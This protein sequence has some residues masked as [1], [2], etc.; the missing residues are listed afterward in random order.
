MQIVKPIIFI[1]LFCGYFLHLKRK[2]SIREEF[3]P[4]IIVTIIG[5]VEYLAGIL[6]LL[7]ITTFLIGIIGVILFI[8]NIYEMFKNKEKIKFNKNI[9]VYILLILWAVYILKGTI[10]IHYDN[11]SHWAMIIREMI[12]TNKLP[13]FQS[14]LILFNSYPPATACFVY[15]VCKYLGSTEAIMLLGQSILILSSLYT[16]C[17][18]CKKENKVNYIIL[19]GT[20]FYIL[21]SNIFI[22]ELLVDTVLP[23]MGLGALVIILYYNENSKNGLFCS[24]PILTLLMLV[25]NS[26]VFFVV[27]DLA[28]W[29]RLFIKN[30]GFKNIF[31][32]K[33]LLLIL[34]PILVQIIWTSHT[35]LVFDNSKMTKHSM[36]VENYIETVNQKE[37]SDINTII[38]GMKTRMIN[39]KDTDNQVLLLTLAVFIFMIIISRKNK[40]LR[41]F[42][43]KMLCLCIITYIFYQI[44]LFGMYM[45]SMPIGEALHLASYSRYFKTMV[46][47]VFGICTITV[48]HFTNNYELSE[49]YR[50]YILKVIFLVIM[51]VPLA[52]SNKEATQLYKRQENSDTSRS[53]ILNYKKIYNIEEEKSYLIYISNDYKDVTDYIYYI[54]KYDFRSSNIRVIKDFSE[55]E[56]MED[57]FNYDYFIILKKDN[58]VIDFLNIIEGDLE[59]NVIRFK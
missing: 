55:L 29:L 9:I 5:L 36:S 39:I 35:D 52:L 10:L 14:N 3:L 2:T 24:I 23:V 4:I 47:F 54:S 7:K 12:I 28:V 21:V 33:Y 22:T 13:N 18:F 6:N 17:A 53:M 16:I 32:T 38:N 45:F 59:T 1:M 34:L 56:K 19:F 11:F 30:N 44:S 15:F 58:E 25:K 50:N 43:V 42:I 51:L 48:L 57:V 46:A 40:D 27:I 20:I 37:E 31:K 8:K 26:G 41:T 49:K